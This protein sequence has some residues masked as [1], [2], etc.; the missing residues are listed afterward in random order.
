MNFLLIDI[1]ELGEWHFAFYFYVYSRYKDK[2]IPNRGHE[3]SRGMWMQGSTYS[4]LRR[5]EVLALHLTIFTPVLILQE[6]VWTSEPV[7][8]QSSVKI[9]TPPPSRIEPSPSSPQLSALLLRLPG[10]YIQCVA[11]SFCHRPP[12]YFT[13][14]F[15]IPQMNII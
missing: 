6:A 13:I 11:H 4:Q 7:W 10:P 12:L 14:H 2:G 9:C 8:T 1:L 15:N 3:G 5:Q